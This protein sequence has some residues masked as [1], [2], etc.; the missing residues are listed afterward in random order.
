MCVVERYMEDTRIQA[1]GFELSEKMRAH[2]V[3]YLHAV[4]GLKQHMLRKILIKLYDDEDLKLGA[5]K[6]FRIHIYIQNQPMLITELRS[7]DILTAIELAVER[8]NLKL[9]QRMNGR[10]EIRK[11]LE[12][13][14]SRMIFN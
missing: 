10:K 9:S 11:R 2:I 1:D 12:H 13:E 3:D 6:F 7:P 8:A 5:D 4:F 14:R